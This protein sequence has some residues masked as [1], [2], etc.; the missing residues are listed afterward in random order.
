MEPLCTLHHELGEHRHCP[1][2]HEVVG[3]DDT[4]YVNHVWLY[5]HA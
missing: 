2:C 3:G 1:R 4:T 5:C